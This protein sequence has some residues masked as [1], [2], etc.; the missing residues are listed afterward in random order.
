MKYPQAQIDQS[1]EYAVSGIH[2]GA[3]LAS[4]ACRSFVETFGSRYAREDLELFLDTAYGPNALLS[5]IANPVI[6]FRIARC[7]GEIIAYAKLAALRA[8]AISPAPDALELCQLY[9]LKPWQGAGVAAALME[10]ALATA[11]SRRAPEIYLTVFDDN[12][13][14]KRFYVRYGFADVGGC[15]FRVGSHID[16][17]RIWR[18]VLD[19]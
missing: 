9:V 8:P 1:I 18:L 15:P 11:R 12:P 17:D 2:D 19:Q 7:E 14:A 13:R 5:E 16:D 10:W 3:R 6:D 4:M